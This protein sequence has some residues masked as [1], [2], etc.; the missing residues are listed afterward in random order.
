MSAGF[1]PLTAGVFT[2]LTGK[3]SIL[4]AYSDWS[5][6]IYSLSF[7][8][9]DI[10]AVDP[11][12]GAFVAL[13]TDVAGVNI[14][15]AALAVVL[16]SRFALPRGHKWAWWYLLF[17]FVWVGISDAYGATQ[18]YLETGAPMLIMPWTFC[19][20]MAVGLLKTRAQVF[21]S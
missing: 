19:V 3:I 13:L 6:W 20:L 4:N 8:F 21:E 1:V 9:G 16:I 2:L 7:G 10:Q 17:A 18:F 11:Q 14:V 5:F 12:A 15:S